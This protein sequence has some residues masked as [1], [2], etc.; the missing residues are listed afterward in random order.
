MRNITKVILA[1]AV[2]VLISICLADTISAIYS[3][4]GIVIVLS[5]TA[6]MLELET[7]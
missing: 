6:A 5:F 3:R 2:V 1:I 4:L 7:E